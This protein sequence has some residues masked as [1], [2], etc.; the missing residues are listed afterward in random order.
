MASDVPA[1]I[2]LM[3]DTLLTNTSST[4]APEDLPQPPNGTS[5][6]FQQCSYPES[7]MYEHTLPVTIICTL[8]IVIGV[9]YSLFGE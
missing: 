7:H 8:F 2:Q 6:I 4:S 9:V 5:S 1:K 3:N